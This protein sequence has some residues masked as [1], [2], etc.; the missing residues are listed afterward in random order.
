ML[1]ILMVQ[2]VFVVNWDGVDEYWIHSY[3]LSTAYDVSTIDLV[4]PSAS[5]SYNTGLFDVKSLA[6]F[7]MMGQMFFF[8]G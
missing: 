8:R 2:N 7:K 6:V 5:N 3:D 4:T 1:G